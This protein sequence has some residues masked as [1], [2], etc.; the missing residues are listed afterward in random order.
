MGK[1]ITIALL[2][3]GSFAWADPTGQGSFQGPKL[4]APSI[5]GPVTSKKKNPPPIKRLQWIDTVFK[6][7]WGNGDK[8][9]DG[10]DA[11]A[12]GANP[13]AGRS[14]AGKNGK[15]GAGSLEMNDTTPKGE[16][17]G[18]PKPPARGGEPPKVV[19]EGG[20]QAIAFDKWYPM[21][22]FI[23]SS[24]GNVNGTVKGIVDKAAA[25][26]V[27]LVV[28]PVTLKTTYANSPDQVNQMAQHACNIVEAGIAPKASVST[29]VVYANTAD[30]MCGNFD[31][32]K[33][34]ASGC[35]SMPSG[36]DANLLQRAKTSGGGEVSG[37]AGAAGQAVPSIEDS[38]SCN[39]TT[40]AHEAQGHSMF[41]WPNGSAAGMGIGDPS[42]TN[43]GGG[44]GGDNWTGLGC[45][46]MRETAIPNDGRWKWDP[47]R[48]IYYTPAST[49]EQMW[50]FQEG[51]QLFRRPKP[52]GPDGGGGTLVGDP[53]PKPDG[54]LVMVDAVSKNG[55]AKSTGGKGGSLIRHKKKTEEAIDQLLGN[56][57]GPRSS[58]SVAPPSGGVSGNAP[59]GGGK[60]DS[61]SL[62]FDDAVG[63]N[64]GGAG[65]ASS[66]SQ[67]SYVPP[68]PGGG[69]GGGG[70]GLTFNDSVAKGDTG[71]TPEAGNAGGG[72]GAANSSSA[73]AGLAAGASPSGDAAS[74]ASV[75]AGSGLNASMDDDFFQRMKS[76]QEPPKKRVKGSALRRDL[77]GAPSTSA[78]AP[79]PPK[80]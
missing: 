1:V 8:N 2:I 52:Q 43:A 45:A 48:K 21:C 22:L 17:K 62:V 33:E 15:G 47:N 49:P 36:T 26:G 20:G 55:K 69:G 14:G 51:R 59:S 68:S 41:G 60:A 3:L 10:S 71:T 57:S 37:S 7:L 34:V 64:G 61:S 75:G 66:S 77:A 19:E 29:C 72:G 58:L 25:C 23:D 53:R 31:Q 63:K 4:V 24:Q 67:E 74:G 18:E 5:P 79:N 12:N 28:W 70:A 32:T 76:L 56:L 27:N 39:A 6:N 11:D 16:A 35:A 73:A 30:Q 78:A 46:R 38:G 65:D 40:V 80:R 13:N 54:T 42:Q 44:G 9:G 50:D